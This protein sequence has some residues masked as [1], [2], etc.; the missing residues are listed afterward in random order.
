MKKPLRLT[1]ALLACIS[2]LSISCNKDDDDDNNTTTPPACSYTTNVLVVGGTQKNILSS[3][4][5]AGATFYS[6]EHYV[7]AGNTEGITMMFDG[8]AAPAAGT[9]TVTTTIPVPAGNVYIEYFETTNAYQP[10]SGS[11]TVEDSGASK[12]YKFCNLTFSNGSVTKTISSRA[13]CN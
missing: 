2:L 10:A 8:G 3:S 11:V 12:I 4:C 5:T 13:T 7:D 1:A 9:Y 6:S